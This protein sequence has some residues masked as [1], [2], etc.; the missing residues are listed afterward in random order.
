MKELV[1][2]TLGQCQPM[3][4]VDHESLVVVLRDV[5]GVIE[6]LY[7]KTYSINRMYTRV[8]CLR[9]ETFYAYA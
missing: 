2:D 6:T 9:I 5:K 1:L 8:V 4:W 3:D 7:F